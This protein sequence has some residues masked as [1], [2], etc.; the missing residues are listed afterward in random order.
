[1]SKLGVQGARLPGIIIRIIGIFQLIVGVVA[2]FYGPLEIYVFYFFSRNGRFHYDGFGFGSLWFGLLVIQ[3]IGYYIIAALLLP[4]GYATLRRCRWALPLSQLILWLWLGGGVVLLLN[5]VV[6][7]PAFLQFDL[8]RNVLLLRLGMTAVFLIII[9]IILPLLL[10]RFY[11]LSAIAEVFAA[12]KSDP[13]WIERLPFPLLVLYVLLGG[14]LIGL[15]LAQFFQAMFP[16]FGRLV[17]G[18]AGAYI[19]SACVVLLAGLVFGLAKRQMW[20]WW[21]AMA[22]FSLMTVSAFMTYS[23]LPLAEIF[24][25]MNL[26]EYEV[27]FLA[28]ATV[29]QDYR[30]VWLLVVPL[31]AILGLLVYVKRYFRSPTETG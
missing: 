11:R 19:I 27:A 23:C 28:E 9:L 6:L 2:A 26:P 24:R 1:M 18:R 15:H 16:V 14:V 20:A 31:L 22:Y 7:T 25:R 8:A 3:N 5:L 21:G 29:L 17:L 12:D 4:T 30:L 10:M 13:T